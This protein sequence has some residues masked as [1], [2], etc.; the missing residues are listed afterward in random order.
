MWGNTVA[1]QKTCGET[2]NNSLCFK[3]KIYEAKFS[4]NSIYIKKI[5]KDH[6]RK[7]K[8]KQFIIKPCRETL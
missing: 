4:T 8:R 2:C 6:F 7:K 5:L 3:E 1:K